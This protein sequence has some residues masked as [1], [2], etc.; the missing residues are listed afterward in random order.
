MSEVR[1]GF[2]TT[3][4]AVSSG[5]DDSISLDCFHMSEAV[6]HDASSSSS[7]CAAFSIVGSRA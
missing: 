4:S 2:G 3:W 6:P 5:A 1:F 7:L